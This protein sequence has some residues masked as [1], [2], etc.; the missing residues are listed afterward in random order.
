MT[1][2][3]HI[4][5]TDEKPKRYEVLTQL[6][7]INSRWRNI[8]QGLGV[9]FND[10]HGMAQRSDSDQTR[11]EYVIQKWFD[12]NGQG[13]GAPVTWNTILNVIN[14]PLVQDITR[15]MRIYEYLKAKS[16]A[17]QD[18]QSKWSYDL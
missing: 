13:E 5:L 18:T 17:Q 14:G 4:L 7:F 8:G 16:S 11:L 10:L 15:A 1:I 6:A 12:M 2:L 9:S 3:Y